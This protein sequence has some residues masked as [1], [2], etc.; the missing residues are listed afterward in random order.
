M[1]RKLEIIVA[2]PAGNT[3]ILVLTPTEISDYQEIASKLL[4][5]DFG[6]DYG[7]RFSVPDS[8]S[9]LGEQVCFILPYD[10]NSGEPPSMDMCGLEFCG[11]A[12]RAFAY[13]RVVCCKDGKLQPTG[14]KKLHIR[15]SGCDYPLTALVDEQNRSCKVQMPAPVNIIQF[16]PEELGIHEENPDLE[17]CFLIDL[18][19]I[20][21]LVLKNI[22]ASREKFDRI[23]N[24]VYQKCGNM[25]AFGIT[26]INGNDMTPVVYVRDID[27]TCFEGS[28][29]SG[30]TAAAVSSTLDKPNG[31]YKYTFRQPAGQLDAI[32]NKSAG[33]IDS[34]ELDGLVE[35]SDI[36]SIEI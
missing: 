34:I 26:F 7:V 23:K 13:Y 4:R 15:V 33:K 20:S 18:E 32:V 14:T 21:H 36:I 3:T 1:T 10:E 35:L 2:N 25:E 22:E 6:K 28:C 29:A 8:D 17:T 31:L 16:S 27:T 19:G 24:Y 12:S 11:N 5:I 9:I 30:T